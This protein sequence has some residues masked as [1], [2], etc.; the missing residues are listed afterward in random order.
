MIPAIHHFLL[1]HVHAIL[2][3]TCVGLVVIT[4]AVFLLIYVPM[5]NKQL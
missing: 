5:R 3:L 4:A 1:H 2:G